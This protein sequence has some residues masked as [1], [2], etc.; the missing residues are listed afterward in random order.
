MTFSLL[1]LSEGIPQGERIFNL[2]ALAVLCS[3]VAHGLSD[4]PGSDWLARRAERQ[5]A[6][7]ERARV[8]A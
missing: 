2:A 5:D 3:I 1:V 6:A 7:R 4:T 8:A